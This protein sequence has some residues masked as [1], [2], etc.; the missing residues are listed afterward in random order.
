MQIFLLIPQCFN[1]LVQL[2]LDV[3][4]SSSQGHQK[5]LKTSSSV[6]TTRRRLCTEK[7]K[8]IIGNPASNKK[9]RCSLKMKGMIKEVLV[10]KDHERNIPLAIS[11]AGPTARILAHCIHR[12]VEF[13][14]TDC[15]FDSIEKLLLS[16]W[17]HSSD[18]VEELDAYLKQPISTFNR[19]LPPLL[20]RMK[21]KRFV[22][23][24]RMQGK[25][26][27]LPL[28]ELVAETGTLVLS[29]NELAQVVS[30][31]I[32]ETCVKKDER[33]YQTSPRNVQDVS[34]LECV[35]NYELSF[36]EVFERKEQ[37]DQDDMYYYGGDYEAEKCTVEYED[38]DMI[39]HFSP[40][41]RFDL[42]LLM[43]RSSR[44][45]K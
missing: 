4:K 29:E 14:W 45:R 31:H 32:V 40:M 19:E 16:D 10:L 15:S 21:N 8:V 1:W 22:W 37:E 18:D 13:H 33:G 30:S 39:K 9:Y 17:C 11:T 24:E 27:E 43:G 34:A 35:S 23:V 20:L 38:I 42:D 5:H 25:D 44:R 2:D 36:D 28:L 3:I 12:N 7:T 6:F 26:A 41:E